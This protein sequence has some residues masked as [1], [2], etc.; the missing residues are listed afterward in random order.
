MSSNRWM[1][2]P[3]RRISGQSVSTSESRPRG[4]IGRE[5][6]IQPSRTPEYEESRRR[7]SAPDLLELDLVEEEIGVDPRHRFHRRERADGSIVD[8]TLVKLGLLV[9]YELDLD[10]APVMLDLRDLRE[11]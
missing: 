6:A 3:L 11:P 8:L 5:G 7:L 4:P 1:T 9:V 2:S 10:G